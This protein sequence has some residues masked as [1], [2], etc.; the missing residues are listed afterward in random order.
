MFENQLPIAP[1]DAIMPAV[2]DVFSVATLVLMALL[3]AWTLYECWRVKSPMYLLILIGG[4]LCFL[5]EP[6]V[7]HLGA[8]WYPQHQQSLTVWRAFNVSLPL[9]VVPGYGLYVGGLAIYLYKKLSAGVT[10][11]QLWTTY[12]VI[13]MLNML[14][15]LPQLALGTYSYF[16]DVPFKILGFPLTWAMTNATIM[17]LSA[18]VLI[19]YKDFLVGL[20]LVFV[21]V[22]VTMANATAQSANGYPLFLALNSG[23]G[24]ATRLLAGCVTIGFCFLTIHLISLKFCQPA[25]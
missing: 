21:P 18:A 11:S 9:W 2:N 20:K 16:G 19:A 8:V 17:M 3:L 12:F 6:I 1:V 25:R 14:L 7:D 13:W 15:E 4:T 22:L 5:Q 24:S 10:V 23:A